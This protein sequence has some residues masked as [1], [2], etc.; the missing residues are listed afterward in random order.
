MNPIVFWRIFSVIVT[1]FATANV[2][3]GVDQH[4][5][6]NK[7][8]VS[9]RVRLH[10]IEADLTIKEQELDSLRAKLGDKNEQVGV[11]AAEV[12]H[13]RNTV[14]EMRRST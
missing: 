1:L 2:A 4:R 3:F 10:E 14:N 6:R 9:Y 8:Q 12:A 5:K 7:E 13:L 11:L